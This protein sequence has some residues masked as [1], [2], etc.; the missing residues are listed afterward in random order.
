MFRLRLFVDETLKGFSKEGGFLTMATGTVKWFN[1]AK[2]YGFISPEGGG[3]DVF[4]HF[5]A[6]DMEG[7]KT[8]K[9]GQRVE[10]DMVEGPRGLQ[11]TKIQLDF[12]D[13]NVET[14]ETGAEEPA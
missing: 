8:L 11:A 9:Q 5:T 3:A 4:A 12:N 2:G 10:F 6:I 7:Y 1:N 14:V 13:A